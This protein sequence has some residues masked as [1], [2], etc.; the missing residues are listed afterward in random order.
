MQRKKHLTF[1]A[2]TVLGFLPVVSLWIIGID[3]GFM[4]GMEMIAKGSMLGYFI[5]FGI[6]LGAVGVW[7]LFQILLKLIFPDAYDDSI[8]FYR[9]HLMCGSVGFLLCGVFFVVTYPTIALFCPLPLAVAYYLYNKC[10]KF[11][12]LNYL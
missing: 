6:I 2:E 5:I 1:L 3:A 9:F 10:R 4:A 12:Q 11:E 8:S 7:G